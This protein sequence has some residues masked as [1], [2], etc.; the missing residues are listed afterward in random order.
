MTC[1]NMAKAI[2]TVID[3]PLFDENGEVSEAVKKAMSVGQDC[4]EKM[5]EAK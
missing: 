5:A 3:A 1:V 4:L 2:K